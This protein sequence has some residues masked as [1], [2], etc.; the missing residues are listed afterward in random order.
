MKLDNIKT[1]GI[2]CLSG[3]FIGSIV[4]TTN[5]ITFS[6]NQEKI[7]INFCFKE[8]EDKKIMTRFEGGGND[9]TV[10]FE[11][12]LLNDESQGI[13]RPFPFANFDNGDQLYF[14]LWVRKIAQP[15]AEINYSIYVKNGRN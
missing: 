2:D 5:E 4:D 1:N 11:L 7:T 6:R 13:T 10:F 3:S 9:L 15:Y 14:Q 12:P 8:K